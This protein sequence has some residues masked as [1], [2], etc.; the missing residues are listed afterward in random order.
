MTRRPIFWIV[1]GALGLAGAVTAL[2]LFTV[3]LPNVSVDITM[4]REAA[5]AEAAALADRLGWGPEDARSAAS[6][7]QVD[8]EVQTYVELEGGGRDAFQGLMDVG[9]YEPYQWR[10]RRFAEGEVEETSVSFSPAGTPYGFRLRLAEDDA[11][12]GNLTPPEAQFAAAQAVA[13][14][15]LDLT[16]YDL[17]ES[18][19]ET[20]PGGRVDHTFVYERGDITLA[21][22]RF[23]LRLVVSGNRLSQ[24][25]HFV[26]VPEAFSRRYADMRS[27][28]D[29]I[30]L[31]S[32]SI[33]LLLYVLLGAGVGS[34][35]L[36]RKRWIEWRTALAWGAVTAT[37]FG[38]NAINALPLSWMSYDTAVSANL[39]IFQNIASAGAIA[40]LGAPI[41]AFFFLAGESLGRKAFPDHLQQ[42]RF[43]SPEV[44]ASNSALGITVGAYLFVGLQVGY[45]VL[46]YMGTSRLE[47]WWSP[48]DALVQP[49]LLATYFPWLQAVSTSLFAALWEESI[50]RAVPL[51][52][53]ALIG[54]RYGRR[55]M[56]VWG[57]VAFQAVVFAAGHAN[58]PQQPA[59]ARVVELSIPAFAWGAVYVF[60]GLVPTILAH[61]LYDLALISSVLFASDAMIDQGVIVGVAAIPLLVVLWARRGGRGT[62]TSPEWSFNRAWSAPPLPAAVSAPT[63]ASEEESSG[64]SIDPPS[65]LSTGL[66]RSH[67][68]GELANEP[69]GVAT[70]VAPE[71]ATRLPFSVGVFGAAGA[72][73]FALWVGTLLMGEAPPRLGVTRGEAVEIAQAR[74]LERGF[75][76]DGWTPSAFTDDGVSSGH[77]YVFEEAGEEEY[78]ALFGE[79]LPPPQWIVRFVDWNASPEER[80]EEFLVNISVDG[81]VRRAVH[82]LPEGRAGAVLDEA[83]ARE[84]A[85]RA[86]PPG[87]WEEVS[88]EESAHESRTDWDFT[89]RDPSVLTEVAGE[90][91]ASITVSGNEVGN[92]RRFVH[93]PEEWARAQREAASRRSVIS[94]GLI[95]VL[96]LMFG[97]G[98][99]VAIVVWSRRGLETR[100]LWIGSAVGCTALALST[101]NAWPA[102]IAVFSTA[103]P[104]GFQAGGA[105]FGLLL[106]A[107]IGGAAIGLVI[108]LGHSW[109]QARSRVATS[110]LVGPSIGLLIAGAGS[111]VGELSGG[112]PGLPDYSAAGELV[113]TLSAPLGAVVP[114]LFLTGAMLL[115]AVATQR[116]RGHPFLG[117]VTGFAIVA[118]GAVLV[119][120]ALQ[121][122]PVIWVASA[123]VAAAGMWALTRLIGNRPALAPMIFGTMMVLSAVEALLAGAYPGSTPG[124]LLAIMVIAGLAWRWS[125]E[126][127][128]PEIS[129]LGR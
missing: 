37:L 88:A 115:L 48:A 17:V 72:V 26:F 89:F 75:A 109:A 123:F 58:Y 61:F 11:G 69:G 6:F 38:L 100:P 84:L 4:D 97:V 104:F 19:S 15:P 91:R 101:A 51:A 78:Q 44:A 24:L 40:I 126:L 96:I 12:P 66:R 76:L 39:F 43:W 110:I 36:L 107:L 45:V 63:R 106:V 5:M 90:G 92:V 125:K 70:D 108:A 81:T 31:V 124:Q 34:A 27:T 59:Y 103:Q 85:R 74:V 33:F 41:L 30:A 1:L 117:S 49:D 20:L 2:Q 102:T 65:G 28:N 99:V 21:D 23:R 118:L 7:G 25:T 14:W 54:A 50:F 80:V 114:L 64:D 116:F 105:A 47:G 29:S 62:S 121:D 56:W 3:A 98:A 16:P 18:S 120:S 8:S 79:F 57:M 82:Q 71:A 22:A 86:L 55:N 42:W 127:G 122:S 13:A 35:L 32:Q 95:F 53:A 93:V 112:V 129:A 52:C 10:V 111:L 46:F 119:P 77:E 67:A 128:R 113:P 68:G 9:V 73:G 87:S 83:S 94:L 60:F